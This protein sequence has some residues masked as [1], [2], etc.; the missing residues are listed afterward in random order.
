MGYDYSSLY[1]H[2]RARL[3]CAYRTETLYEKREKMKKREKGK[4]KKK[5]KKDESVAPIKNNKKKHTGTQS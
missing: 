3:D 4:K 2:G 5:K 1:C